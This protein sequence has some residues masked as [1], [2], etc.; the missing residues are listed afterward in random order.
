MIYELRTYTIPEGRMPDILR[1][2]ETVTFGLFER[3]GIEVT[4]F[5]TTRGASEI[6]YICKFADEEAMRKAWDA[7]RAD[8][9][10]IEAKSRSEENGPIVSNVDSKVLSPAPF[11]LHG[12]R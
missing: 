5:W 4:D 6:V 2:F 3:H 1:R 10:W 9:D 7:F 12:S 11:S 8:P